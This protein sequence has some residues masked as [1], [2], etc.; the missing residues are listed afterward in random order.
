MKKLSID[1]DNLNLVGGT[2]VVLRRQIFDTNEYYNKRGKDM[3]EHFYAIVLNKF[4]SR[5]TDNRYYI[6]D[7]KCGQRNSEPMRWNLKKKQR[8]KK[9]FI[10]C[11]KQKSDK[12]GFN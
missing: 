11:L 2:I 7:F 5:D 8:C 4:E 9:L 6:T 1:F 3:Y 12:N 10:K